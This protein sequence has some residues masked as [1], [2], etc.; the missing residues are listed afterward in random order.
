MDLWSPCGVH[1]DFPIVAP[2]RF[3]CFSGL[4]EVFTLPSIFH[5]EWVDST[6]HSMDSIWNFFWLGP[7]P[8]SHS[9]A[10]MDSIWNVYGMDHSMVSPWSSPCGFHMDSMEFPNPDSIDYFIWIP[11]NIPHGMVRDLIRIMNVI[12]YVPIL[13]YYIYKEG[14]KCIDQG[15]NIG[16]DDT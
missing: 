10:T 6:P 1:V 8:I 12:I 7:Y 14:K 4:Q 11:W 5:M 15:L 13:I 3:V 9:I 2:P 16:P